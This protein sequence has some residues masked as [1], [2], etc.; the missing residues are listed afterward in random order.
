MTFGI[1]SYSS[2]KSV[3]MMLTPP[4][5]VFFVFTQ[6]EVL[7]HIGLENVSRSE[8]M[9]LSTY[10]SFFGEAIA[11]ERANEP[12]VCFGSSLSISINGLV[13]SENHLSEDNFDCLAI[14]NPVMP[15]G[16]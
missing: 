7:E 11:C 12:S 2:T 3:K 16:T 4:G 13:F 15:L 14:G 8:D 10:C 9:A 5:P 6:F 1:K